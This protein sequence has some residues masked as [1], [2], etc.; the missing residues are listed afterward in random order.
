MEAGHAFILVRR[1]RLGQSENLTISSMFEILSHALPVT[2]DVHAATKRILLGARRDDSGG[3]AGRGSPDPLGLL[4]RLNF[5]VFGQ[6]GGQTGRCGR[7]LHHTSLLMTSNPAS[8]L[9]S[10]PFPVTFP[11]ILPVFCGF[12]GEVLTLF[13]HASYFSN[14][15]I[16]KTYIYL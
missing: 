13:Q 7:N 3:L 5:T 8:E 11:P 10:G 9:S 2:P 12:R 14:D 15:Q 4:D 1:E 16:C 6:T